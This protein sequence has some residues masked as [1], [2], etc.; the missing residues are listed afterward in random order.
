MMTMEKHNDGGPV[1]EKTGKAKDDLMLERDER[2]AAA[3]LADGMGKFDDL[4]APGV[5]D[6]ARLEQLVAA[7]RNESR[8]KLWRDLALL[9]TI[10]CFVL[11]GMNFLLT[12]EPAAFFAIQAAGSAGGVLWLVLTALRSPRGNWKGRW[13]E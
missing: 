11:G 1:M 2:E 7:T 3:W 6:A 5:P 8:R 12:A 13:T 4:F 9:W 10:G